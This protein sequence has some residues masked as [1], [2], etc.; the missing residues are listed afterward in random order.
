MSMAE[1]TVRCM[2]SIDGAPE[3]PWESLTPEEQ[4]AA[5][6]RLRDRMKAGIEEYYGQHPEEWNSIRNS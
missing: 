5:G 4:Y 2:I 6:V 3:V 1:I